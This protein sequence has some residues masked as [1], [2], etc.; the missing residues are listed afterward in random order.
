MAYRAVEKERA[1]HLMVLDRQAENT[2][3]AVY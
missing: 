1:A 3:M 2:M